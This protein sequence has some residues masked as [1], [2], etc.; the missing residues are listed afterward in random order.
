MVGG[1]YQHLGDNDLI[2]DIFLLIRYYTFSHSSRRTSHHGLK[3][4]SACDGRNVRNVDSWNMTVNTKI[5][6]EKFVGLGIEPL[7]SEP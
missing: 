4:A 5:N 2:F 6:G 3:A 7:R 1:N